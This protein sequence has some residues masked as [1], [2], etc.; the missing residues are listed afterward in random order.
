MS[1]LAEW[2]TY[3]LR[4]ANKVK[5]CEKL[6]GGPIFS[7]PKTRQQLF[8]KWDTRLMGGPGTDQRL[9]RQVYRHDF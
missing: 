9:E 6:E 8:N 7:L 2:Q 5:I 4:S 1:D 3:S